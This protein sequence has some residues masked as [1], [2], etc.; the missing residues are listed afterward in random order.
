M[1][2]TNI[3]KP[4]STLVT[5]RSLIPLLANEVKPQC[6]WTALQQRKYHYDFLGCLKQS[7]SEKKAGLLSGNK[8]MSASFT[9]FIASFRWKTYYNIINTAIWV[10][11]QIQIKVTRMCIILNYKLLLIAAESSAETLNLVTSHYI[12]YIVGQTSFYTVSWISEA[13]RSL[14]V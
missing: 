4:C 12:A 11:F 10:A 9:L 2:C 7:C 8:L 5:L 14:A 3:F 1:P 6:T 13:Y